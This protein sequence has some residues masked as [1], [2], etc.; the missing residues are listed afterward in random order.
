MALGLS[1]ARG[2]VKEVADALG[3]DPARLGKRHAVIGEKSIA[4]AVLER[5]VHEAHRMELQEESMRR[6]RRPE[7]EGTCRQCRVKS[8][9]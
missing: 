6:K 1:Y 4:D 3:I 9:F 2:S 8:R 5:V 7:P